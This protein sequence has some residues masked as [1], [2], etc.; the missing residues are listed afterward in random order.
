ML[1]AV[2]PDRAAQ[3]NSMKDFRIIVDAGS[4]KTAVCVASRGDAAPQFSRFELEGCNALTVND[5]ALSSIVRKIV[6]CSNVAGEGTVEWYGAGC[7]T[8]AV[9]LRVE[10]AWLRQLPGVEATAQSDLAGAA[11]SLF[12]SDKGIAC[13]LGTGSNSCLWDGS[14]IVSNIPPLG[15]ILGDE[16]SGARL[17]AR[18]LSDT[19]RGMLDTELGH[20]FLE[21][22]GVDKGTALENV[23][24]RSGASAWLARFVPFLKKH[25]AR[26]GVQRIL[27]ESFAAFV[28][29]N[30]AL[31]PA[32]RNYPVAFTG[33]VAY[34]FRAVLE[35]V[36]S[37]H[38]YSISCVTK[39]PMEGLIKN[40]TL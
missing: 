7:A 40:I 4:T 1:P 28:E 18:L 37:E 10:E 38:G 24:R 17:G 8:E 3:D 21:E 16:G 6:E 22:Y 34:H 39:D 36:C 15:F 31:Y 20:E 9:C 5:D 12:G 33:G 32:S 14:R 11:R 2:W 13:I 26:S 30:V 25:E 27:R 35:E 23:Y 29:R 19:L